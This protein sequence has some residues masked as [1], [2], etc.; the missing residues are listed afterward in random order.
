MDVLFF[1]DHPILFL[2]GTKKLHFDSFTQH[3]IGD[4]ERAIKPC[5]VKWR[6]RQLRV[7]LVVFCLP[8]VL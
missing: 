8:K 3:K 5:M 2:Q 6:I 7:W 4:L 1:C